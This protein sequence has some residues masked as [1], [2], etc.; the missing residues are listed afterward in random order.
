ME[1]IKCDCGEHK[2]CVRKV[3]SDKNGKIFVKTAEHFNC[4]QIKK[5]ILQGVDLHN[6]YVR[7]KIGCHCIDECE[8]S[9]SLYNLPI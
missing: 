9:H 6:C 2:E 5:Q 1:D 7:S 8:L 3:H 4:G